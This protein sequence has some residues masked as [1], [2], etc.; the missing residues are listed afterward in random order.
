MYSR[1]RCPRSQTRRGPEGF[2]CYAAVVRVLVANG[3]TKCLAKILRSVAVA[4]PLI[5]ANAASARSPAVRQPL[6]LS[7]PKQA[8]IYRPVSIELSV[9]AKARGVVQGD[10]TH[11]AYDADRDGTY[12]RV[13]ALV[14]DP[15]GKLGVFPGF[16]LRAKP[17]GPWRLMV[18]WTPTRIAAH[19]VA[20]RMDVGLGRKRY[21]YRQ[22]I[23][24]PVD[25]LGTRGA[26]GFLQPP[27]VRS[28]SYLRQQ[29]V[30]GP[31]RSLWLFGAARAW[32]VRSGND[33]KGWAAI[34]SGHAGTPVDWDDGTQF[35]DLRW[36]GKGAF[37]RE[38]YPID[39]TKVI[40]ALRRFL[41]GL[42]P[43]RLQPVGRV[44][45]LA[46]SIPSPGRALGL[47][48]DD[49]RALYGWVFSPTGTGKIMVS[50][51][52]PGRYR[53]EL[54]D[55]WT[56]KLARTRTLHVR[57]RRPLT[58]DAAELL[59]SWRMAAGTLSHGQRKLRGYDLAFKL[60]LARRPTD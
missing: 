6:A 34:F 1:C 35:G 54:F 12:L 24:T 44:R 14:T 36:R 55:P 47:V 19:R 42:D 37:S 48:R 41:S 20:L 29:R 4:L 45:G 40:T 21:R 57:S 46:L 5:A 2:F 53:C 38:R 32:V 10:D 58:V 9:P 8:A 16:A 25:V 26:V 18:R 60:I 22:D 52:A 49:R 7:V 15:G 23:D 13:E 28:P 3:R 30:A 31:A 51:L 39:H 59:A 11:D 27:H 50:G 33:A 17:G 43:D 56:G